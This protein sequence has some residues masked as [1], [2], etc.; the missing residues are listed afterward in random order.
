M[1][2]S[3]LE[4]EPDPSGNGNPFG[5][6]FPIRGLQRGRQCDR[7]MCQKAGRLPLSFQITRSGCLIMYG[8]ILLAYMG[9]FWSL[10]GIQLLNVQL[11]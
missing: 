5:L 1:Y 8:E 2:A 4:L 7:M 6:K 3:E 9:V 10:K 11:A